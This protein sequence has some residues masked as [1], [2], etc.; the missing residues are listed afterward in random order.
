MSESSHRG[1]IYF[2]V[3]FVTS[4]GV[5]IT[6]YLLL[7]IHEIE[8]NLKKKNQHLIVCGVSYLINFAAGIL[9]DRYI[10]A[11]KEENIWERKERPARTKSDKKNRYFRRKEDLQHCT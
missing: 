2:I 5:K 6:G 10:K 11:G 7:C 9:E 4:H 8:F 3:T 1:P